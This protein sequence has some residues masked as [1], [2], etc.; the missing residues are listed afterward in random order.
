MDTQRLEQLWRQVRGNRARL[1]VVVSVL[2]IGLLLWGRLI[3]LERVPRIATA[4]P[5]KTQQPADDATNADADP[6]PAGP[7]DEGLTDP[8]NPTG[9]NDSSPPALQPLSPKADDPQGRDN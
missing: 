2:A 6:A 9:V 3:L 5:D 1:G 8:Y 7:A 4:D